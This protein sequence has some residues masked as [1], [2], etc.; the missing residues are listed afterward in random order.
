M[1]LVRKVISAMILQIRNCMYL[2]MSPFWSIFHS[3]AFM[4]S[5]MMQPERSSVLLIRLEL[6][7]MIH[8]MSL[9]HHLLLIHHMWLIQHLSL[10]LCLE[11]IKTPPPSRP[12][13]N[14]KSTKL[15]EFV[16]SSYSPGFASFIA[17]VH[18]LFEPTSYKEAISDPLWQTAMAEELAS[19]YQ[20][21][22]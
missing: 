2:A 14:K 9:I 15:P 7:L 13:R 3:I 17:N 20:T 21:H 18:R 11:I 19:L 16:Y 8:H 22:T 1:V 10:I 12:Y 6:T 5:H 4:F